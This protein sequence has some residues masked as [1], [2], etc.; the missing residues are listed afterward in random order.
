M[1]WFFF[2][3]F[4]V[5]LFVWGGG[6]FLSVNCLSINYLLIYFGAVWMA[7]EEV[8]YSFFTTGNEVIKNAVKTPNFILSFF[9][10]LGQTG[11]F[12]G[13]ILASR[14]YV[15][16]PCTRGTAVF[17]FWWINIKLNCQWSR[18]ESQLMYSDQAL[19]SK[20]LK[21]EGHLYACCEL[22]Q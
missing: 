18:E 3:V 21:S 9:H 19:H 15:W 13:P 11:T 10:P 16:H 20:A 8:F 6:G 7:V 4:F 22:M 5:C 1:S 12:D 2:L 14:P 17:D